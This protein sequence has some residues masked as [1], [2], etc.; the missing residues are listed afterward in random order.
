MS[1][2]ARQLRAVGEATHTTRGVAQ[3]AL[4]WVRIS[5]ERVA[6]AEQRTEKVRS[7][8]KVRA[9]DTLRS[10]S[11]GARE[12][13]AAERKLRR[14]AEARVAGAEAARDRAESAFEDLQQRSQAEHESIATHAAQA[15]EEADKSVAKA[16]SDLERDFDRRLS[17]MRTEVQEEADRRVAAAEQ[18]AADAEAAAAE[19][20][21]TAVRLETEIERRVMDGTA[22]VRREAEESVHKLVEKVEREAEEAA[23][24]RAEDQL[25]L[26]SDRIRIQAERR[27]ER[28]REAT[29]DEI[30][31]ST[32]RAKREAQ[33]AVA[34]T[35]PVWLRGESTASTAGYRTF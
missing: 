30:K 20:H 24:A 14:E 13:I 6:E 10:F 11:S 3:Q 17:E 15:R 31:A 29:E 16:V 21:E 7:V 26:E 34:E 28:V 4:E 25:R 35:A 33:A 18:R 27:E 32:K 22:D 2:P 5:E 8:V 19:S 1:D 9:M 23:R 12:R